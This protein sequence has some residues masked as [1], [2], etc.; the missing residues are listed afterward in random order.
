MNDKNNRESLTLSHVFLVLFPKKDWLVTLQFRYNYLNKIA[1]ITI[2]SSLR[3]LNLILAKCPAL[4]FYISQYENHLQVIEYACMSELS[5]LRNAMHVHLTCNTFHD[6]TL[7]KSDK[8]GNKSNILTEAKY[9]IRNCWFLVR[10]SY[11]RLGHL[12]EYFLHSCTNSSPSTPLVWLY[13]ILWRN[14][15]VKIL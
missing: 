1:I 11:S 9:L 3:L 13:R 4:L 7:S 6:S 2:T 12:P 5:R 8:R 15:K 14:V 10:I